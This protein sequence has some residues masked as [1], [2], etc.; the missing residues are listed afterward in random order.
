MSTAKPRESEPA[1]CLAFRQEV[2]E[3]VADRAVTVTNAIPSPSLRD[4]EQ[5]SPEL[6]EITFRPR[7]VFLLDPDDHLVHRALGGGADLVALLG[8]G[9]LRRHGR[10]RCARRRRPARV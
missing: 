5:T 4:L 8:R 1:T 10:G 7:K 6:P 3:I 9:L 2:S